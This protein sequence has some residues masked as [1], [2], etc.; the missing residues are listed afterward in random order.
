MLLASGCRNLPPPEPV[1]PVVKPAPL[2]LLRPLDGRVGQVLTVN[3]RLRFVV[4]DYSLTSLPVLGDELDLWRGPSIVGRLKVSGPILN[5]T[6]VADI[7]SG[8]PQVADLARPVLEKAAEAALAPRAEGDVRPGATT[9][10]SPT[11]P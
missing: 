9:T 2:R 11:G 8:E 6:A 7:V 3:P 5:T 1:K 4:L 10:A